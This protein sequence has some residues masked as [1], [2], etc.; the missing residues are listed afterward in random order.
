MSRLAPRASEVAGVQGVTGWAGAQEGFQRAA[1][2]V[3]ADGRR[4]SRVGEGSHG[5]RAGPEGAPAAS[6]GP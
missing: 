1:G 3:A 5:G 2:S 6:V 4:S